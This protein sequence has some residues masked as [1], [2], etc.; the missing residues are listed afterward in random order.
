MKRMKKRVICPECK[1]EKV[2]M[3]PNKWDDLEE[4]KCHTCNGKGLMIRIVDV[5]YKP[6]DYAG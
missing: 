1:G 6:I 4:E 3:Y 5:T 2:V